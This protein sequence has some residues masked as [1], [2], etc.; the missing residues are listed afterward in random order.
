MHFDVPADS[1]SQ[2]GIL[3]LS[4]N[5]GIGLSIQCQD[6]ERIFISYHGSAQSMVDINL[7]EMTPIDTDTSKF[8]KD[9]PADFE[10]T[11]VE[12]WVLKPA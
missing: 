3:N 1:T 5:S 12:Y 9:V 7:S 10:L 8:P 4:G 2:L 6:N 11:R